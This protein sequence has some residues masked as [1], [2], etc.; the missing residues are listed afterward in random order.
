MEVSVVAVS[1]AVATV[2]ESDEVALVRPAA[3]A[4]RVFDHLD[5]P[6]SG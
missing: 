2:D 6:I 3:M 1:F 4:Q 5:E